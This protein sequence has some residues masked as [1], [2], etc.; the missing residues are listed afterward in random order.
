MYTYF[1]GRW[2]C[3]RYGLSPETHKDHNGSRHRPHRRRQESSAQPPGDGRDAAQQFRR[4][5]TPLRRATGALAASSSR[6]ARLLK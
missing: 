5:G 4:R 3:S 2:A 1:P 6:V